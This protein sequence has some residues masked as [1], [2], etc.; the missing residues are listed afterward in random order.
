MAQKYVFNQNKKKLLAPEMDF[1][2]RKLDKLRNENIRAEMD[3]KQPVAEE[4]ERNQLIWF[5]RVRRMTN[6]S[7]PK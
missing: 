7:W 3:T 2:R 6:D 4:I 5:G 1:P